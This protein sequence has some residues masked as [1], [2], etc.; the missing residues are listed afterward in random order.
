MDELFSFPEFVDFPLSL[1]LAMLN[2][3]V[4]MKKYAAAI[5][6]SINPGDVVIDIGSGTGILGFL[7]AQYGAA[8]VQGIEKSR[9][10]EYAKKIKDQSFFDSKIAFH[11]LDILQDKLPEIEADVLVCELFGNFGIEEELVEIIKKAKDAFIKPNGRMIPEQLSLHIAPVQCS[12]AY[13]ELANWNIELCDIDFSPLQQLAYNAI[14]QI[15][16]EPVRMLASPSEIAHLDLYQLN[17]TVFKEVGFEVS[18]AG[19]L[20]GMA[21]WFETQLAPGII[22]NTGPDAPATHWGQILFPI[23]DPVELAVQDRV[24]FQFEEKRDANDVIWR[25]SGTISHDN[26]KASEFEYFAQRSL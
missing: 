25:W 16:S 3:E 4:R 10:A 21:G 15:Q 8:E 2:D 11:Q 22:L 5:S 1:H 20:H 14:Y 17:T 13:R 26:N 12:K 24:T 19:T 9:L 6:K 7:A 18:T 23:G